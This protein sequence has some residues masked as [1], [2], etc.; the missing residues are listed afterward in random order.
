MQ[1]TPLGLTLI[2]VIVAMLLFSVGALGL[3]AS[4][5][6]ISR[7]MTMSL[8]RSRSSVIARTRNEGAQSR[9]CASTSGGSETVQGVRST[10][11]VATGNTMSVDQILERNTANGMHIDQFRS[12]VLCN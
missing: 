5:A 12:A 2:E 1:R 3:A 7:Q 10:W 8:L 9:S 4:S 6:A 11:A